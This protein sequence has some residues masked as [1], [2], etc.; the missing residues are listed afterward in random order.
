VETLRVEPP[1][2]V[3]C[4]P[5]SGALELLLVGSAASLLEGDDLSICLSVSGDV[6][7]VVRSVAAQVAH[8]CPNG[9]A[10]RQR[11]RVTASKS[12]RVL[13]DV[14]PLIIA[15]DANHSSEFLVDLDESSR[16]IVQDT[17]VLGRTGEA[18]FSSVFQT[19]TTV[20]RAATTVFEDGL[21]TSLRGAH[22]PAG[23]NGNRVLSNVVAIGW[24]PPLR[25]GSLALASG[26]RLARSLSVDASTATRSVADTVSCWWRSAV[27]PA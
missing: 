15:G 25:S 5:R 16:V 24:D 22:G 21:D 12:A 13:W 17:V 3:K 26:G 6:P 1:L 27:S 14:E 20:R 4:I 19:Q 10:T 8:P 9:G 7:V 11:I 23:L 2:T 18:P